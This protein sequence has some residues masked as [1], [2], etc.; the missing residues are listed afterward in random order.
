[1]E[2]KERDREGGRERERERESSLQ[3]TP[4]A[5]RILNCSLPQVWKNFLAML[6]RKAYSITTRRNPFATPPPHT[7]APHPTRPTPTPTM[8]PTPFTPPPRHHH[9]HHHH[10][11][12]YHHHHARG[13]SGSHIKCINP[14]ATLIVENVNIMVDYEEKISRFKQGG[15]PWFGETIRIYAR[16]C[17]VCQN[18]IQQSGG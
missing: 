10:H 15:R 8:D 6:W 3:T 17:R 18:I 5:N 16:L 13:P 7:Q 1:M 4:R 14:K 11:K 2:A 12:H 9:H